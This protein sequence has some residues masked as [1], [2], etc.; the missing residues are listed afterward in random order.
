MFDGFKTA[1]AK[2]ATLS[3]TQ[4]AALSKFFDFFTGYIS[5]QVILVQRL[6][7][8]VLVDNRAVNQGML[9]SGMGMGTM[10]TIGVL[11][12]MLLPALAK[13]K[14]KANTIKSL[15]NAKQIARALQSYADDHGGRLPS[16][17]NWSDAILPA[18]G[19]S[20]FV[21]PR[22]HNGVSKPNRCDYALNKA[23]AGKLLADLNPNAVL[24]YESPS[25]GW[26]ASGGKADFQRAYELIP[27]LTGG[28][29]TV[30]VDVSGLGR[31][32]SPFEIQRLEWGGE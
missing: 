32:V 20:W 13:A 9:S 19:F 24:I 10:G 22:Y 23:V 27:R 14:A 17:D 5:H 4:R 8:G 25:A 6:P 11:S 21:S 18:L 15:N 1:M 30:M 16:E 7:D 31:Q 28:K 12:S 3:Q 29:I 26:N 2:D